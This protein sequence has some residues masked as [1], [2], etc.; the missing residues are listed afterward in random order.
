M[1][2]VPVIIHLIVLYLI[3]DWCFQ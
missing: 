1:L 2:V 3:K